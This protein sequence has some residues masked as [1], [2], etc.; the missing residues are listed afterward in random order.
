LV[1]VAISAL[2]AAPAPDASVLPSLNVAHMLRGY[3]YA[4]SAIAD[5]AALGGFGPSDNLPRRLDRSDVPP[6]AISLIAL[7][8]EGL[9]FE[10]ASRGFRVILANTTRGQVALHA[11]DSRLSI[12]REALAADGTWK[13]IEYLPSSWC[14]NSFHQ[15]FLP[16]AQYW[17]FAAPDYEGT[18]HTTMRFVLRGL[19]SDGVI[20]S[21]EFSGWVN[22]GQFSVEQGHSPA[23]LMDP[24]ED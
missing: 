2:G 15:V 3:F 23:S 1:A 19:A 24:Y 13:P 7:P 9:P 12:V 14:G 4:G 18:E 10:G 21:N 6:G 20:Y 8:E 22:P 5:E 17:S 11:S 16:A